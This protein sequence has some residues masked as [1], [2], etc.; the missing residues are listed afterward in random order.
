MKH[1]GPPPDDLLNLPLADP[2]S[3]APGTRP[4]EAQ[5]L[6]P[7]D[8]SGAADEPVEEEALLPAADPDEVRFVQ[9]IRSGLFDLAAVLLAVAIVAVGSW[10][11][12]ARLLQ[13]T[14]PAFALFAVAFSFLYSVVPLTFWGRT[15]GMALVGLVARTADG[16]ALTIQQAIK[17][18]LGALLTV[19]LIATPLVLMFTG[20]SLADRLSDSDVSWS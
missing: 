11:L 3:L 13:A 19:V 5:D 6:L 14:A 20:R 8:E 4:L 18:W 7:F 2:N 1:P 10:L 9:R 16:S 15:P 17:R 12:G